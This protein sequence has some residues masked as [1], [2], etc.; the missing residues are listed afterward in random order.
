MLPSLK[1]IGTIC[2]TTILSLFIS[3]SYSYITN[4]SGC[5]QGVLQTD[6]GPAALEA[7]YSANT[8]NTKWYSDGTRLTGAGIPGTCTYDNALSLPA[9]QTKPGYTF[10]GWRLHVAAAP[11]CLIP[12]TLIG[13]SSSSY[14]DEFGYEPE[15]N[16]G[17]SI[18]E[19][20]DTDFGVTDLSSLR[21][22]VGGYDAGVWGVSWGQTALV[23]GDALCAEDDGSGAPDIEGISSLDLYSQDIIMNCYC[24]ART[25]ITSTG[26]CNFASSNWVWNQEGSFDGQ[27][28]V[29][30]VSDPEDPGF[31]PMYPDGYCDVYPVDECRSTCAELCASSA[32][33]GVE[34]SIF[35]GLVAQ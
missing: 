21:S 10:G 11:A 24:R 35:T 31:D 26:Q 5:N 15:T 12:S 25:Y 22:V 20:W 8:I 18:P 32:A 34:S 2:F 9:A 14:A 30:G 17:S 19:S 16:F 29:M 28:C 33:Y 4:S 23:I 3:P 27:G 1:Q 6:T 13:A 7:N